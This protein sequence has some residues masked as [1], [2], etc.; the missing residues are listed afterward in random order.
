MY[1]V[2]FIFQPSHYDDEFYRLNEEIDKV[3]TSMAGFCGVEKWKSEN[4]NKYVVHYYWD[5]LDSLKEFSGNPYHVEAKRNYKKWYKGFHIIISEIIK[6]YG[7]G[8]LGDHIAPNERLS[9]K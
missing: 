1:C 3:A 2:S 9:A 4:E 8:L 6:S 5:D 7:D